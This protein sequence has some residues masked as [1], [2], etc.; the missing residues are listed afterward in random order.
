MYSN[1]MSSAMR[2]KVFVSCYL[3]TR[4]SLQSRV[5]ELAEHQRCYSGVLASTSPSFARTSQDREIDKDFS[6][7]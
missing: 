4:R 1:N 3:Q 7:T 6:R 5:G 2:F